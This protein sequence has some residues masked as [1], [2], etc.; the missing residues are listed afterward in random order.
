MRFEVCMKAK[1]Q[2]DNKKASKQTK[3]KPDD[4]TQGHS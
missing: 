4:K 2:D 1:S 3:K